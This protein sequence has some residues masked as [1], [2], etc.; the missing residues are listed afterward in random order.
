ACLGA[1]LLVGGGVAF[2]VMNQ[3]PGYRS[4]VPVTAATRL[5]WTFVGG[6]KSLPEAPMEM[7]LYEWKNQRFDLYV[8]PEVDPA[9]GPG[10]LFISPEARPSGWGAWQKVCVEQKV[11]FAAPHGTNDERPF[12][13]RVR[14]ALDVL[15][16]VRR[17][18]KT[19]PDR[20]YI[21]G[22][23]GGGRVACRIAF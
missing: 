7:S 10:V 5:D 11:I 12:A 3:V 21:V 14:I 16:E 8:P 6:K 23:A 1:F 19:D 15:D 18:N 17:T 9:G 2:L 13:E 20:T 4:G 22:F